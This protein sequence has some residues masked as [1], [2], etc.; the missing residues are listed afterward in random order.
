MESPNRSGP[1]GIAG[2][3]RTS[4]PRP[5]TARGSKIVT[6]YEQYLGSNTRILT[7]N[8]VNEARFG[9]TRFFNSIGTLSAAFNTN[10]VGALGIPG[11]QS[12]R[13][14]TTWGIPSDLA[15][16][17]R[18]QR[19]R[20]QHRRA[21]RHQDNTLQLV[22]NLSW[23]RRASTPS[24][25]ASNTIAQNFNQVGNQ[26]SRG[27]FV[28]QPN[29]TQ[30][31]TQSGGDAFAEFLLGDLY[32]SEVAVAIA[33][34]N[35]LRNS[36]AA[37]IDDTWK[38]TPKLTLSLGLRYE[39][40]PPFLD[41]QGNLFTVYQPYFDQT[42]ASADRYP[43]FMRQGSCTDPYAGIRIRW[44]Q[45][46]ATCSN[47]K[48]A[49][50]LAQTHYRNFAPRIGIA[51][52]PNPKWVVRLGA[53]D[54][55]NQD[56]GNGSYF[57]MARQIAGRFRVNST[58]GTPTLFWSNALA[59]ASGGANPQIT[60]PF[61]F[62]AKYSHNT[63]Y[64]WEYLANVQRQFGN[65]WV[66]EVGYLG[67][68]SRHLYGFLDGNQPF[69]GTTP[70]ASRLPYNTFGVIQLVNDGAN[71]HYNAGS[72]KLTRRFSAGLSFITSYTYSKSIDE[73]SG[74]R[75]QGYDTLYPQESFCLQCEKGLSAFDV[76]NRLI[77]SVLYELPVGRGRG[78]NLTNS[79]V[80]ALAGGWQV[81]GIWTVQS[82]LP[83]VIT[84]GGFDRSNTGVG[85]DRP[86]ATGISPYA[87]NPTPS[88]WL[89]PDAFVEQPV[90]TWGNV[91]RNTVLTPG[92]F[93]LDFE[94]HKEFTMPY[95]EHHKLQFRFEAFNVLNHPVW[96]NPAV[97]ILAG[98]A[99][100]G[101]PATAPHQG[102]GVITG[103][104]INMRQLQLALKYFF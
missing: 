2:A 79:F 53:G 65:N 80:N 90:G 7:P 31:P 52:S 58:Q 37:L 41:T 73:T 33:N 40:T 104:Q 69:P 81:G 32:Q 59:A 26:F 44:P 82:G 38:V 67:S 66:L 45:I 101:A 13:S 76:R 64:S 55:Y 17:R 83:E 61:A 8:L 20:R 95:S 84:L 50:E 86:N 49:G 97:S 9:Y 6:N 46:T 27:N 42:P 103:T 92:I 99:F 72:V 57:D 14:P 102:F 28:F 62:E 19:H 23:T 36:Y 96:S 16:R 34:A 56:I 60:S 11:L 5:R 71:G 1:A 18:L 51:W 74:I 100:A 3:T 35:F 85:Y 89:N 48:E 21:V 63:S 77:N 93:A 68:L 87:A 43:V 39:L 88:R 29:A 94:A 12:G 30:S 25:S 47:G 98:A 75:V 24:A 78:M 4:P 54:F 15:H 22:D 70:L 91:G 10:V